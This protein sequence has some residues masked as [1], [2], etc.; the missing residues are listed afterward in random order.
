MHTNCDACD[1]DADTAMLVRAMSHDGP[2]LI[3]VLQF[4]TKST[5]QNCQIRLRSQLAAGAEQEYVAL[6]DM[7]SMRRP[8]QTYSSGSLF[9][10]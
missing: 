3:G 2:F 9:C 8:L 4:S 7:E 5:A 1:D 6:G 10:G